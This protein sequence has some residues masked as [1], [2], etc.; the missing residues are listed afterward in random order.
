MKLHL[1]RK[2]Y[3]LKCERTNFGGSSLDRNVCFVSFK[4]QNLH[5]VDGDQITDSYG[6]VYCSEKQYKNTM[7][8][9]FTLTVS[10]H[11]QSSNHLTHSNLNKGNLFP[12]LRLIIFVFHYLFQCSSGNLSV[13]MN[14]LLCLMPAATFRQHF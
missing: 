2:R 9:Y 13:I 6:Y 11:F 7:R 12:Y 1:Q 4:V 3:R 14:I 10:F 5:L 8:F